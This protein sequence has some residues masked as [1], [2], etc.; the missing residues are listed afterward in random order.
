MKLLDD[1]LFVEGVDD[2]ES[3]DGLG[4]ENDED[5]LKGLQKKASEVEDEAGNPKDIL[6]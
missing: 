2:P 5:L 1:D 6:K 4:E 3:S